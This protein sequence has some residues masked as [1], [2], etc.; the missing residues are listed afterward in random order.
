MK[1]SNNEIISIKLLKKK[2]KKS[3][4]F[5]FESCKKCKYICESNKINFILSLQ[6]ENDPIETSLSISLN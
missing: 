6:T 1:T 5:E 3:T 2:N 4:Y